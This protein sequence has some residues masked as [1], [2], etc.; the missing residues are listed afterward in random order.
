MDCPTL[1]RKLDAYLEGRLPADESAWVE[2]HLASC[3]ECRAERDLIGL[4]NDASLD[5][6]APLPADFTDQ[7]MARVGAETNL[8]WPWLQ[9]RWTLHQYT[10]AVQALAATVAVAAGFS[11]LL[12]WEEQTASLLTF[13]VRLQTLVEILR[14][15][16]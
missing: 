9:K 16:L 11:L 1:H 14:G 10:S 2:V 3:P 6:L 5:A 13:S 8:L 12:T 4:L 15:P 7:V